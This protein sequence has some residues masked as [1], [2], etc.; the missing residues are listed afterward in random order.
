MNVTFRRTQTGAF[1]LVGDREWH[2]AIH[3][4]DLSPEQVEAIEWGIR[5]RRPSFVIA[6]D[7]AGLWDLIHDIA[8]AT[9]PEP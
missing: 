6:M 3:I 2:Y 7:A 8:E 1:P 4:E 9:R 5:G